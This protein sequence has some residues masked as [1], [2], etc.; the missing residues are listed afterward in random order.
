M[1]YA[2]AIEKQSVPLDLSVE[3]EGVGGVVGLSPTV[4]IRNAATVNSYLDWADN[5]FKTSGWTNKFGSM[6]GVGVGGYQRTFD[7]S[8]VPAIVAGMALAA[9]YHVG[10]V[11]V[12]GVTIVGDDLDLL[13]IESVGADMTFLRKLATN[14][15]VETSG[16]P[17]KLVLY[18]DNGTTVLKTWDLND[19]FSGAI[20]PTVGTPARRSAGY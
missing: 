10:P 12:L 14:K 20:V 17:G 8:L 18:D 16:N 4:A 1:S 5:T 13:F 11:V 19:E 3:L 6:L 9:E 15:L 7:M 2:V